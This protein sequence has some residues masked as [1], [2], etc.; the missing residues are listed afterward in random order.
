M[1]FQ[2]GEDLTN[3]IKER[4]K[5]NWDGAHVVCNQGMEMFSQVHV[6]CEK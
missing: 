6:I 1:I 5:T 2:C 4:I 3:Q